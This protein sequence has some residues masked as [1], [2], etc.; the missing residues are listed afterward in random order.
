MHP[1]IGSTELLP[2]NDTR[3]LCGRW[4]KKLS[5]N[6]VFVV[7]LDIKIQTGGNQG[8]A[9]EGQSIRRK[10]A[11]PIITVY[12]AENLPRSFSLDSLSYSPHNNNHHQCY[13]RFSWIFEIV[14]DSS[15]KKTS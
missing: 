6:K 10:N 14:F 3:R 1:Q 12:I 5:M 8:L 4:D 7:E 9:K 2:K 15:K 13:T 11:G